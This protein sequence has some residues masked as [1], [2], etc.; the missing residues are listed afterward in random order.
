[1]NTFGLN[2][3]LNFLLPAKVSIM[4]RIAK[5][6]LQIPLIWDMSQGIATMLLLREEVVTNAAI[7]KDQIIKSNGYYW[8]NYLITQFFTPVKG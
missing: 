6:N 5:G 4:E 3:I 1:M 2:L 7:Q 8:V